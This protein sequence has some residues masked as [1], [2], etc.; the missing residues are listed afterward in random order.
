MLSGDLQYGTVVHAFSC[1]I[2]FAL[3]A[4]A[5]PSQQCTT[6]GSVYRAERIIWL[7]SQL[8]QL[9]W[10]A[11]TIDKEISLRTG[12]PP[13]IE[14]DFCDLTLP[15][16]HRSPHLVTHSADD[17]SYI[18]VS[19]PEFSRTTSWTTG[20]PGDLQLTIIKSKTCKLLYSTSAL[21]KSD[22]E[23]LRD[24]RQLDEELE[25]WRHS[26]PIPYRPAMAFSDDMVAHNVPGADVHI[27][28]KTSITHL[29]YHYLAAA[30]HRAIGRCYDC[31]AGEG[32]SSSA[33]ITV[34]ASRSTLIYLRAAVDGMAGSDT[35]FW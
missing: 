5:Q 23:L 25:R 10:M 33:A 9:F 31:A 22:A 6:K 1:R 27:L 34:Q 24:I 30:I 16:D 20:L 12:Q 3:G 28:M 2:L 29:E 21:Q 8:R 26:V 11:Y 32:V 14:D 17:S 35:A 19:R 15:Q 18:N 7:E 4:H 13:S